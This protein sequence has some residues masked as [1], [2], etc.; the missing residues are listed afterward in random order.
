LWDVFSR[1]A[2]WSAGFD[3]YAASKRK[4]GT[5]EVGVE[6]LKEMERWRLALAL[7]DAELPAVIICS[8]TKGRP[9]TLSLNQLPFHISGL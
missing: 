7:D 1:E 3:Q 5:S 4:R 9:V 8:E 2:V 6:F